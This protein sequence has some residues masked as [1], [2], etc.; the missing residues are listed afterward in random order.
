MRYTLNGTYASP[1]LIPSDAAG[2]KGMVIQASQDE[3]GTY[4]M[5]APMHVTGL[6][7]V[8]G[9]TYIHGAPSCSPITSFDTVAA[10]GVCSNIVTYLFSGWDSKRALVA[11]VRH[12]LRIRG[13]EEGM[14]R[15]HVY[16]SGESSKEGWKLEG[17][18][19]RKYDNDCVLSTSCRT[20]TGKSE[21]IIRVSIQHTIRSNN[22][23][24]INAPIK[25]MRR[26]SKEQLLQSQLVLARGN[27]QTFDG[28][29]L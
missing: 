4:S 5:R 14:V 15:P 23:Y 20:L 2:L 24:S 10:S 12:V 8:R 9:C 11:K 21:R 26:E 1:S 28:L 29:M 3:I 13:C 17:L 16:N 22:T 19:I 7:P 27:H 25:R 6:I 18:L